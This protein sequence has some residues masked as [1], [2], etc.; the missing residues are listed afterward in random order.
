MLRVGSKLSIYFHL[1]NRLILLAA[2][3]FI[4][5]IS[6]W[7]LMLILTYAFL[8][9]CLRSEATDFGFVARLFAIDAW[10]LTFFRFMTLVEAYVACEVL[11]VLRFFDRFILSHLGWFGFPLRALSFLISLLHYQKFWFLLRA[12]GF[13][14]SLRRYHNSLLNYFIGFL[15]ILGLVSKLFAF[16]ALLAILRL[17]ARFV[18]FLARFFAVFEEMAILITDGAFHLAFVCY[19]YVR[20]VF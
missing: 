5:L 16:F 6:L 7:L 2:L 15:A 14:I 20:I 3:L 17:V 12:L 9:N 13:F 18:A 8:L 10:Q 1:F 11:S 19:F 4:G